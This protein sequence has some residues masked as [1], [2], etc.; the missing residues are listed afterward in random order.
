M[1]HA[2]TDIITVLYRADSYLV[3]IHQFTSIN[4]MELNVMILDWLE[5]YKDEGNCD[6]KVYWMKWSMNVMKLTEWK[7]SD[8][9]QLKLWKECQRNELWKAGGK[10]D[11]REV[12]KLKSRAV[13]DWW[14]WN[15]RN[16]ELAQADKGDQFQ[17]HSHSFHKTKWNEEGRNESWRNWSRRKWNGS[18]NH[19]HLI[20]WNERQWIMNGLNE[21]WTAPCGQ[22][23]WV[24]PAFV[25]SIFIKLTE[26]NWIW[27]NWTGATVL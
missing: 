19:I 14:K 25:H 9:T 7:Q 10:S 6:M 2:L 16:N 26:F 20:H 3:I 17:F 1:A 23:K 18:W 11:I 22:C 21:V 13:S 24:A 5:R 12:V 27:L 8:W 15:Q 4:W